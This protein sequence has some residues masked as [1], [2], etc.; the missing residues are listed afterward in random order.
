L[1]ARDE[2]IWWP[3]GGQHRSALIRIAQVCEAASCAAAIL[4]DK[5]HGGLFEGALTSC[6]V[7]QQDARVIM[8]VSA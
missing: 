4:L 8:V 6:P 2:W 1:A 3:Q 5:H 7:A